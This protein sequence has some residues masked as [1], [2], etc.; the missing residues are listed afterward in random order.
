[1]VKV[2]RGVG[3][4][5]ERGIQFN[6]YTKT[7]K[8]VKPQSPIGKA[9]KENLHSFTESCMYFISQMSLRNAS[10]FKQL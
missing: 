9:Q 10:S 1:M 6:M 8:F 4:E 3:E 7:L 2:Q 5:G